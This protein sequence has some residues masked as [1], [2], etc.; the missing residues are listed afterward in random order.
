M[1]APP[2]F[3]IGS[4]RS[5]TTLLR[6]M[7]TAHP[8]IVIPPECGFAIWWA[9]KYADWREADAG[10]ERLQE[11]VRD[12]QSSRK[13]ET[14]QL[15]PAPLTEAL[16]DARPQTYAQ[17]VDG[18]YRHYAAVHGKPAARWGD[19]NNFY[20]S[21]IPEIRA[22]FPGAQFVHI[23]R[24]GRDVACSYRQINRAAHTSAYAPKLPDEPSAIAAEWSANIA[25][26]RA[27]FEKLGWESVCEL[28]YEDLVSRPERELR[29]LCEFLGAPFDA[30][31]LDYAE[32]N[33]RDSLEPADFLAWKALTLE[34][35]RAEQAGRFQ[36][37]LSAG[38]IAEFEAVAGATLALYGYAGHFHSSSR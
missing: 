21:H 38:Q 2:L 18:I 4:P 17:L 8:G 9:K 33:R 12:L 15:D 16:R 10:G 30:A 22:L 6:L 1:K 29:K 19:K 25:A 31:M 23:V 13:F 32:Q 7:L 5:G 34:P 11:F 35:P 3:V 27:A 24:D 28:R 20:L 14:W 36:R 37:D 26:I